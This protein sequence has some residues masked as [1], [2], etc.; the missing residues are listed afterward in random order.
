MELLDAFVNNE[1]GLESLN[2]LSEI[3]FVMEFF[4]HDLGQLLGNMTTQLDGVQAQT[5]VYNLVVAVKYLHSTG[6]MHRDLK[7]QNI[8][9]K[10][11]CTI[12]ICDFGYARNFAYSE[13]ATEKVTRT[14]PL[15]PVCFSRWYRP[16]E[17]C[18]K[19]S[20]YD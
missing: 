2:M 3:Y 14:R 4:D 18:A 5:L 8:L 9:V 1:A 10:N 13:E 17:I 12:R 20:Q 6:I 7:P 19:K 16:P 15:S 11:D